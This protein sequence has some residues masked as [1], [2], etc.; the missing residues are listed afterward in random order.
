MI[1]KPVN[2]QGN[3]PNATG[4]RW[5]T[6]ILVT[7]SRRS[8]TKTSLFF[9]FCKLSSP[10]Q[11]LY[12]LR[13]GTTTSNN[14][15]FSMVCNNYCS[16]AWNRQ[17]LR[18]QKFQ[19]DIDQFSLIDGFPRCRCPDYIFKVAFMSW[20]CSKRRTQGTATDADKHTRIKGSPWPHVHTYCCKIVEYCG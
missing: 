17:K 8:I 4:N 5:T 3:R 12:F 10:D 14:Y 16:H 9:N 19:K 13:T 18:S 1:I 20:K 15:R 6:G 2:F 11:N 7:C